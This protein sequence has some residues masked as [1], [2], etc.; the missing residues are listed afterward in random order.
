MLFGSIYIDEGCVSS[1][2]GP[3]SLLISSA[4]HRFNR[5]TVT[6][7]YATFHRQ[8]LF[9]SICAVSRGFNRSRAIKMPKGECSKDY[10]SHEQRKEKI[11]ETG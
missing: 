6:V 5:S 2:S 1:P 11:I 4:F 10:K 7:D 3:I 8:N 9:S